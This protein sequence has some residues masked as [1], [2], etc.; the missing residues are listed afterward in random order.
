V[1]ME[2][3]TTFFDAPAILEA[4]EL[5]GARPTESPLKSFVDEVA[6]P[7]ADMNVMFPILIELILQLYREELPAEKRYQVTVA[8]LDAIWKH[9]NARS[10]LQNLRA[11]TQRLFGLNHVGKEQFDD[12]FDRWL[13]LMENPIIPG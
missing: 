3:Q 13:K 11:N 4:V 2:Y 9:S 5:T 6:S 8:I 1:G 10:S 12:C 7:N